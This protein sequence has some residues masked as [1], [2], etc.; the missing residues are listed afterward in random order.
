LR[1][2]GLPFSA[3]ISSTVTTAAINA[4]LTTP[5]GIDT[6]QNAS[7]LLGLN[8]SKTR[9]TELLNTQ[10][11]HVVFTLPQQIAAVAYPP[12]RW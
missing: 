6:V 5:A 4:T 7:P 9:Q 10:Y 3:A 8:G 2:A 1:F 11:F 12:S